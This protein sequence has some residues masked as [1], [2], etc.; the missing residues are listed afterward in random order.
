MGSQRWPSGHGP[1]RNVIP[2]GV[3]ITSNMYDAVEEF[4][5]DFRYAPRQ[6]QYGEAALVQLLAKTSQGYAQA[7][8]RGPNVGPRGGSQMRLTGRTFVT[9]SGGVSTPRPKWSSQAWRI[10]VRRITSRYY[11]GWKVKRLAPNVWEVYNESREAFFIEIGAHPTSTRK[12]P[13]RIRTYAYLRTL[14][15]V[16]TTNAA[17]RILDLSLGARG[18]RM[19]T[20]GTGARFSTPTGSVGG[21][22]G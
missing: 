12:R 1:S 17:H 2:G 5:R 22:Y 6:F 4:L 3:G 13:R 14:R 8:S 18:A 9:D 21:T 16:K 15:F 19:P 20:I 7:L 10:P 11:Q